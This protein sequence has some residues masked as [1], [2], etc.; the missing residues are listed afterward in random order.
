[1]ISNFVGSLLTGYLNNEQLNFSGLK[2]V[3]LEL[4]DVYS[5]MN[6]TLKF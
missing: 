4:S 2:W 6:L 3:M 5:C 1:M